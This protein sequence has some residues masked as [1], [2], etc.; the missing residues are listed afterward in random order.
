MKRRSRQFRDAQLLLGSLES[1]VAEEDL[2]ACGDG[3]LGFPERVH[4]EVFVRPV[5]W[6]KDL[7]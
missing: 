2:F 1:E 3:A 5:G 7:L 4:N 6:G